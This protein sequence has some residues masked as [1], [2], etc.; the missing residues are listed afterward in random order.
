MVLHQYRVLSPDGMNRRELLRRV[1]FSLPL[2]N[3]STFNCCIKS[4][5]I[6]EPGLAV[7]T[8]IPTRCQ[9]PKTA[10]DAPPH[11]KIDRPLRHYGRVTFTSCYLVPLDDTTGSAFP[12]EKDTLPF[13][14]GTHAVSIILD[15]VKS[16]AQPSSTM[17]LWSCSRKLCLQLNIRS[18][19][20][21]YHDIQ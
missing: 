2:Y 13:Y 14:C 6:L 10:N 8:W 17:E 9:R 3:P 19:S 1:G 21:R 7:R 15:S 18:F 4:R 5:N 11:P 16:L 12:S 20:T